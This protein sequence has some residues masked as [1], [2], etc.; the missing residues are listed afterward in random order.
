MTFS[1][2]LCCLADVQCNVSI[3]SSLICQYIYHYMN[4]SVGMLQVDYYVVAWV[5]FDHSHKKRK[6]SLETR[7][8]YIEIILVSWNLPNGS[9]HQ[10]WI[11]RNMAIS[12]GDKLLAGAFHVVTDKIEADILQITKKWNWKWIFIHQGY[13][14]RK[15]PAINA[16]FASKYVH[17]QRWYLKF[18]KNAK[19]FP[20]KYWSVKQ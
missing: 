17:L 12:E 18:G 6:D 1:Y 4:N 5:C 11:L 9:K 15:I 2:L 3:R 10:G 8:V 16:S 14:F 19:M 7:A 20:Q 13:F